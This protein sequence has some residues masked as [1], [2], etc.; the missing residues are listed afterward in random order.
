MIYQRRTS[1]HA[2]QVARSQLAVRLGL[3]VYSAICAAILLRTAVLV[4]Q[5]PDTVWT[6]RFILMVSAPIMLPFRL[7]PAAQRSVVGNATLADLT[8]LLVLFAIP[9]LL[10]GR[11]KRSPPS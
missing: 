3:G 7:A 8:A 6:S 4:F 2:A 9:L 11:G 5:F 1:R 10:I